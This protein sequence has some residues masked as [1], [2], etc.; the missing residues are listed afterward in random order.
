[1]SRKGRYEVFQGGDDKFYF[2]RIAGNG[3]TEHPSQGYSTKGNAI[4]AIGR[5]MEDTSHYVICDRPEEVQLVTGE[6]G[7]VDPAAG[8]YAHV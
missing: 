1:M 6:D 4:A 3:E 8:I 2:N 5:C 7:S